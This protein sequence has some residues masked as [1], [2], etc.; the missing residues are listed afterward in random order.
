VRIG[1]GKYTTYRVMARDVID[2]ALGRALAT[3]RPSDTA[4]RR[5]VGAADRDELDRI[6]LELARQADVAAVHPDAAARLVARHGTEAEA[7]VVLARELD[8]L[9]PLLPGRPFLEAEVAWAVRRELA[10]TVDDV[11]SRRLRLSPEMADRGASV[12]PR[13][14]SIMANELGWDDERCRREADRYVANA[15]R[16]YGVPPA[17]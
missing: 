11:L 9:R 8:L 10:L 16:E 13:V 2:G 15:Q 5:L 7:V 3:S 4:D 6:A 1:G 12:A 14:A 17:A